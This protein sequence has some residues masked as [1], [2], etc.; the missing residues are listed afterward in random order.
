ML[1]KF[2]SIFPWNIDLASLL[3]RVFMGG[4]MAYSHGWGKLMKWE[5]L[6]MDFAEP[7]GMSMSTAA[8]LTIFAELF[9]AL[10]IIAGLLTRFACIPIII[11]MA[12]AAFNAHAGDPLDDREGSLTYMA[13]FLA[14]FFLGAGKYSLD[15]LLFRKRS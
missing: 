13:S 11:C 14:M 6:K 3:L 9:C 1:K 2:L 15:F 7:F 4:F 5:E 10:F 8:G 12:V